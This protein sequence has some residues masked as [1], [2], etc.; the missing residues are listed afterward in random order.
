[1]IGQRE[2]FAFFAWARGRGRWQQ[3]DGS[4]WNCQGCRNV[5][6]HMQE[7][8]TVSEQAEERIARVMARYP[9]ADKQHVINYLNLR[10]EGYTQYQALIM[11]GL[12]DPEAERRTAR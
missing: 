9:Y 8:R 11:S 10:D 12:S 1:M 5:W 2:G 3:C 7:V 4:G 6:V